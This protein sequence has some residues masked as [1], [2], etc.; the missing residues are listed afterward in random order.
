[1]GDD[2]EDHL[3]LHI[4]GHLAQHSGPDSLMVA[5]SRATDRE[6]D[7]IYGAQVHVAIVALFFLQFCYDFQDTAIM[8][9]KI[10]H[11]TLLKPCF[12]TSSGTGVLCC[13]T[14][15]SH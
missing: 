4:L 11:I 8:L 15:S 3:D 13:W 12:K 1:M 5:R 6:K 2:G 9:M 7:G 10:S 14:A